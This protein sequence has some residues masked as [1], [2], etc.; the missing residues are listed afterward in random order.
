MNIQTI[1]IQSPGDMG[2]GV[3][4][5][6]R[7]RGFEVICALHGR[8]E[9]SR[10]LAQAAG[11][12]DC[13]TLEE[14]VGQA[15]LVLSILPPS[16]AQALGND[17]AGAIRKTG[18]TPIIAECNAIS[19]QTAIR[20]GDTITGAG[21]TFVDAGIIGLAPGKSDAPT[22]F[23][24]SGPDTKAMHA[25]HGGGIVVH[26]LGSDIGQASAMK[27][28]YASVTKGTMTL[29]AAA[30]TAAQSFGLSDAYQRE[31]QSSMPAIWAAM[32]RNV[33]R[34]PLDAG[35][36]IGE[37][38][39]IA[40]TFEDA[41]LPRGFHEGAAAMFELLDRTPIAKETRETVDPNRTLHD[42]LT[43]YV[44]ALRQKQSD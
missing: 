3:G 7:A 15:D 13:G 42:A 40:D 26:D 31:V 30:L 14:L 33:P 2:H 20:I 6:L 11:I 32:E 5:D 9:R 10:T 8:S 43:M 19:P 44:A 35:R 24:C 23:Y 12:T 25:L 36:W 27:M 41:G 29:H 22:R 4:R 37:M 1:A 39:E 38:H 18:K 34:L 17:L 28:V 16:A 21:A